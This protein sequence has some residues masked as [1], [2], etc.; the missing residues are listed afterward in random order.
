MRWRLP[1][2]CID[3]FPV[4]PNGCSSATFSLARLYPNCSA[5]QSLEH[6][7]PRTVDKNGDENDHADDERIKVRIGVGHHQAILHSLDQHRAEH[8]SKHATATA[9]KAGAAQN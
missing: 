9:E 5:L 2:D 8:R 6:C 1:C 3:F 4:I 7:R